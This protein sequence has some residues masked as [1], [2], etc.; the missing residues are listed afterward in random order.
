MYFDLK[1]LS[2]ASSVPPTVA[3][4]YA[5]AVPVLSPNEVTFAV[6]RLAVRLTVDLQDRHPV[7]VSLLPDG[8]FLTG[9]LMRR[10]VFPMQMI[11]ITSLRARRWVQPETSARKSGD[12]QLMPAL[13][14]RFVALIVG[15]MG[16]PQLGEIVDAL[17]HENPKCLRIVS[18]FSGAAHTREADETALSC[19]WQGHIGSGLGVEGPGANLP[20]GYRYKA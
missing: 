17:E 19:H 12:S 6:D 18:M 3:H 16:D 8:L 11:Q 10:L 4:V 9:M 2:L 5:T 14:G 1:Q 20:G 7:L 15:S 13:G